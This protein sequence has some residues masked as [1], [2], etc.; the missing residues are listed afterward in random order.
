MKTILCVDDIESNLYTIEA[1][2]QTKKNNAYQLILVQSAEDAFM[3]LLKHRVDLILMDIM[4]PGID[5]FEATKMIKQ[6]KKTKD[7]PIIFLTA[8]K[9]SDTISKCFS[10]G[11]VD[12]ISKPYNESELFARVSFHIKLVEQKKMLQKEREI[13]QSI[14]DMQKNFIVISSGSYPILTN[15]AFLSFFGVDNKE[16]FMMKYHCIANHFVHEE[17]L[18]YQ[19]P[20]DETEWIEKLIEQQSK[21]EVVVALQD[22]RT[23]LKR[24]FTIDAKKF[25]TEYLL[26]LSE[27]TDIYLSKK[28]LE[29]SAFI[30]ELTGI[31]NRK[32]FDEVLAEKITKANI[33]GNSLAVIFFDIDHFKNV[34]DTYGHLIGDSVLQEVVKV[35]KC[36]VRESDIF[37]RWG[38]EEFI[39]LLEGV[40]REIATNKAESIR[41]DIEKTT[42]KEIEKVTCSFGVTLYKA[43]EDTNAFLDRVDKALYYTKEHGR[44]MVYFIE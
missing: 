33:E 38:G 40:T 41:Q 22:K 12:Y 14:I 15:K 4:M 6:N 18:F 2:F 32:K 26:V 1:L 17:G 37:A 23:L 9:D 44:N 36:S 27:I 43:Q 28:I 34:N 31:L 5:G 10:V 16:E 7:I 30:D 20:A 13:G 19:N 35:A 24:Y 8:K 11:G 21:T 42:F 39:I 29:K 3:Q 25:E